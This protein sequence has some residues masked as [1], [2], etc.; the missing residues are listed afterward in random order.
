MNPHLTKGLLIVI[1][2]ID[3]SGKSTLAKHLAH[4]L[5]NRG[6]PIRL[7]R[8]PGGSPLGTHLRTLVQEQTMPLCPKAEYLLFAADRAQHI[9]QVIKPSLEHG[10]VVIS[11]RMADSSLVYQG[12][13]RGLDKEMIKCINAWAMEDMTPDITFYVRVSAPVAIKRILS[14]NAELSAFEK[15]HYSFIE[16]LIQGFDELFENKPNGYIIDGEQSETAVANQALEYVV[17]WI[18][19]NNLFK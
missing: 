19:R 11:D 12:Y 9:Q 6:L 5:I 10:M 17:S 16:R 1:E 18:Q 4:A 8:E 14:R 15:E 13:G 7:T 3:G 2:G